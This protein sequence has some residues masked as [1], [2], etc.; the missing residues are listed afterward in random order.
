MRARGLRSK[1]GAEHICAVGS[2]GRAFAED[3]A[4][5][6]VFADVVAAACASAVDGAHAHEVV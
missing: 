5:E 3:E 4:L 1:A 6:V 2:S